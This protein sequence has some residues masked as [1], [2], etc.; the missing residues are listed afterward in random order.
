MTET[1]CASAAV[2]VKAGANANS[3][4]VASSAT[5]TQF[6]NQ[7]EGTIA[8]ITRKDWV[9][10]YAGLSADV[11]KVLEEAASNMAAS[12]VVQY[13]M[14]GYTSRYEAETMLDVLRDGFLRAISVLRDIKQQTFLGKA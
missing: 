7:A 1:L 5:L 12:Y 3:T 6:I 13:D 14:S 10:T 8:T 11:K 4:I 9:A 2:I